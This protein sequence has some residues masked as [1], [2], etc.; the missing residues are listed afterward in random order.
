MGYRK[1]PLFVEQLRGG[2]VASLRAIQ[3][4]ARALLAARRQ[5]FREGTIKATQS[6]IRPKR[7]ERV[8]DGATRTGQ[9]VALCL[10]GPLIMVSLA[11]IVVL[12]QLMADVFGDSPVDSSQSDIVAFMIT[13]ITLG[14][15]MMAAWTWFQWVRT[16]GFGLFSPEA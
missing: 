4:Q 16:G 3:A 1:R 2:F 6:I 5:G 10:L 11:L 8:S 12:N 14:A 15:L 9:I 13:G 7:L